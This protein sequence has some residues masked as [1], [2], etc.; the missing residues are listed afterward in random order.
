MLNKNRKIN[1]YLNDKIVKFHTYTEDIIL[2]KET[3]RSAK[4][5]LDSHK[6]REGIFWRNEL[7]EELGI[8]LN[9]SISSPTSS[10]NKGVYFNGNNPFEI[11]L[12]D[13]NS[14]KI[15]TEMVFT[16]ENANE[17]S[18]IFQDCSLGDYTSHSTIF[19]SDGKMYYANSFSQNP[20]SGTYLCDV[21]S[22]EEIKLLI[23]NA[24][25]NGA[26][27]RRVYINS[28]TL[29]FEKSTGLISA[30]YIASN[31]FKGWIKYI[32]SYNEILTD[33][34]KQYV[35][36]EIS[37][38]KPIP[39]IL[40]LNTYNINDRRVV[41]RTFV[42]NN[43]D[44]N[45]L[46]DK[47]VPVDV[48]AYA[49]SK[50]ILHIRDNDYD[51]VLKWVDSNGDDITNKRPINILKDITADKSQVINFGVDSEVGRKIRYVY[52]QNK[53]YN[54]VKS[55]VIEVEERI[56][57]KYI[58]DD[59][60]AVGLIVQK[61]YIH[62]KDI[63][64]KVGDFRQVS[65]TFVP[66]V[67]RN[68]NVTFATSDETVATIDNSGLVECKSVGSCVI[69]CI[70]ED[71]GLIDTMRIKVEKVISQNDIYMIN[72]DKFGIVSE[73]EGVVIDNNNKNG[74]AN[75]IGITDAIRYASDNGYKGCKLPKGR[76]A[77]DTENGTKSLLFDVEYMEFDITD[78][79]LEIVPCVGVGYEIVSAICANHSKI[80]NGTIIGDR[81]THDYGM[82]IGESNDV[83]IK[84][85]ID[86][87][88]GEYKEDNT[89]TVT[90]DF[91]ESYE[92]WFTKEKSPLPESFTIMPLWN[93][94]MNTVDG[95]CAYV[96]CY[97]SE[98]NYIGAA[99]G[100]N[101][102]LGRKTLLPNTSKIKV[103]LRGQYRLDAVV[104]MTTKT[105]RNTYEFGY[106]FAISKTRDFEINGTKIDKAFGDAIC[107]NDMP[108]GCVSDFRI[109]NCDLSNARR[110]GISF[111]SNGEN[112]LVKGTK[113]HDI[114]GVDPQCGVDVEDYGYCNNLFFDDCDFW[115]NR[116]W[117]I[118]VNLCAWRAEVRNSRFSGG[119][120]SLEGYIL[121]I[122]DN[123]FKTIESENDWKIHK[124][125]GLAVAP[126][127]YK[128]Y[129]NTII[130]GFGSVPPDH[131][132]AFYNNTFIRGSAS[133]N[134]PNI[135]GNKYYDCT[136]GYIPK[137]TDNFIASNEYYEDCVICGE[138]NGG[139]TMPSRTI[140]NS[141]I[142]NSKII[143]NSTIKEFKFTECDVISKD[144]SLYGD[145]GGMTVLDR[146]NLKVEYDFKC[147][148]INSNY[149]GIEFVE[150]NMD[151]SCT[152]II[153]L[154]YNRFA[155]INNNI[156]FNDKFYTDSNP[157]QWMDLRG[158][159]TGTTEFVGNNF[160]KTFESPIISIPTQTDSTLN[161][162][163]FTGGNI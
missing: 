53:K 14:D 41:G 61:M 146:C 118:N 89:K 114:N 148:L 150:C 26:I 111:V 6:Y 88:T 153:N 55:N 161:G 90:K 54:D 84:G 49:L 91:I 40:E 7:N 69:T 98:N 109:I 32:K 2:Y 154:N 78:C 119:V 5:I 108:F 27:H 11:K 82:R 74:I 85:D 138:N 117:D 122:H 31:N 21:E 48:K 3:L 93:T 156:T 143:G 137:D 59:P 97:D 96:Y 128:A 52:L 92:D 127:C 77:I 130:D 24:S 123:I 142:I 60:K 159:G 106:G 63:V 151:L 39:P 133:P 35:F 140:T 71:Q 132:S 116:K 33:I 95:G 125:A 145:K 101:G 17:I 152:P 44:S 129:N 102:Y 149:G 76:Y 28:S 62:P 43:V 20:T 115:N 158:N 9:M 86:L 10:E 72:L 15:T 113:I 124:K 100:N 19:V 56:V 99:N 162:N 136:V 8:D 25:I 163:N 94:D 81:E 58:I 103:S 30:N 37:Y 64:A 104:T 80:I 107:T 66:A 38:T 67:V 22:G 131:N 110:Q 45:P 79:I 65:A 1:R 83:W 68:R 23:D 13:N 160:I 73:G 18:V 75:R 12:T 51:Y 42:R 105:V 134:S 112:T 135:Y 147:N 47:H 36:N 87:G 120:C 70:T 57:D 34:E 50:S 4:V 126:R 139:T 157:L 155:L 46:N 16:I 121:D 144:V 29:L 141:K